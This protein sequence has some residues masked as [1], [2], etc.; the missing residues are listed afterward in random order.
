MMCYSLAWCELY[1]I[2][3][4]VFRRVDLELYDSRCVSAIALTTN[5]YVVPLSPEDMRFKAHFVAT[6]QGNP[7]RAFVKPMPS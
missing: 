5:I 2:F 4:S 6:L 3:A 1:I 7:V